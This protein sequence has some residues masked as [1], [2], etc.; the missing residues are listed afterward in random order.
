[1]IK[2]QDNA[3]EISALRK[4]FDFIDEGKARGYFEDSDI[5]EMEW[6]ELLVVEERVLDGI[7]LLMDLGRK[8][9]PDSFIKKLAQEFEGFA[10]K[11]FEYMEPYKESLA[12]NYPKFYK[13]YIP[14]L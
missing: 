1:M 9:D 6:R 5:K 8:E 14:N 2:I 7:F 4:V 13:V 12:L 3:T 10:R 11:E